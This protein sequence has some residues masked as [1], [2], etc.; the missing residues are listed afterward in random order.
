MESSKIEFSSSV[1]RYAAGQTEENRKASPVY[2][3]YILYYMSRRLWRE[4]EKEGESET[5]GGKKETEN[6]G[7]W[8]RPTLANGPG[9]ESGRRARF[10]VMIL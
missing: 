10:R 4:R 1:L 5:L 8:L 6:E 9:R 7:L 2:P 3:I